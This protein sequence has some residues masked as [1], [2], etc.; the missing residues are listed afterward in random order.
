MITEKIKWRIQL[1]IRSLGEDVSLVPLSVQPDGTPAQF[2]IQEG[3][4]W[5]LTNTFSF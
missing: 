1:N 5:S 3:M 4:T 2:R